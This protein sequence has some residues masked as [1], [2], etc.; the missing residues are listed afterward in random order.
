MSNVIAPLVAVVIPSYKV[1]SHVLSVIASIGKEVSRIYVV[2]D[3]CPEGSGLHVEKNCTDERVRV[4]YHEVNQGV[5]GAVVTGYK[6][7]ILDGMD[8]VVKVDG[9]GQMDPASIPRFIGRIVN[10]QADYTKGNR[11]FD[12]AGLADMPAVRLFGNACLSFVSKVSSG[13]WNVMDPTNGY[14]AI[15]VNI[16]RNLPLDKIDKR[17]FFESDMLFRL[18]ILRAVVHDIPLV[19]TYGL[20]Q[21]NLSILKVAFEFPKKYIACFCKRVFYNYFLRNF[22]VGSI[23]LL[24][25]SGLFVSGLI[26][27]LVKWHGA[28]VS[29][30]PT[31]T[32]TIMLAMLPILLGFQLLLA[33]L[34]YDVSSVPVS[35]MHELL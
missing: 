20:E 30:V 4:L 23:E 12:I 19:S 6:Q 24:A 28:Y 27:G 10:G 3:K 9:D 25:G 35:P 22:N 29:G 18:G 31:A 1:K 14:T 13:Y 17:Y 7:S 21:S 33:A 8:I 2:D 5:G 32:G 34:N 16:L 26:Y 15:H 11:F